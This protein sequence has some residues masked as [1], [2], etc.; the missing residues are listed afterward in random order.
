MASPTKYAFSFL[1]LISLLAAVS[2]CG[3]SP[4]TLSSRA[5]L[6]RVMKHHP[7]AMGAS[8]RPEQAEAVL[9]AARGSFDPKLAGSISAK[10]FEN[11]E[12]YDIRTVGLKV[13]TWFGVSLNAGFDENSG[14]FLDPERTTPANGLGYAG[15]SLSLG[16]GLFMDKRRAE[17]RKAQ[18]V[19]YM[20]EAERRI[21]LNELK[22]KAGKAYWDWFATYHMKGVQEE[23]MRAA[24]I[25]FRAV[26]RSAEVGD[27]PSIDTVEARIQLQNRTIS[28]QKAEVDLMNARAQL[29]VFLW[30]EGLIPL[31][32]DS[33]TVPEAMDSFTL[34]LV[35][36]SLALQVADLLRDHPVVVSI[37]ADIE[38]GDI[39][40]RWALEQLKPTIDL[41]YNALTGRVGEPELLNGFNTNDRT[42]GVDIEMPLFLR[43]ERGQLQLAQLKLQDLEF[44]R[45]DMERKLDFQYRMAVNDWNLS[46]DQF[47][48]VTRNADDSEELLEG[49]RNL[50]RSG[51]SS[52]FMVNSREMGYIKA[53]LKAIESMSKNKIARLKVYNVLGVLNEVE[54][55]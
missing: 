22:L 12:Y 49:E 18:L 7:M 31:E 32:L 50:F 54:L 28:L 52:L 24:D 23:A 39:S 46:I 47:S 26:K 19:E 48:V 35:P 27:V 51:E 14:L 20:N 5:F 6:E 38:S 29:Q 30:S 16:E 21:M 33:L 4:T 44:K 55:R 10:D 2:V 34:S 25:R 3:Q 45:L 36:D 53:R 11:K 17:L 37:N 40:R 1:T 41:K 42:W 15:I 13:P 8:L 9:R 43:K